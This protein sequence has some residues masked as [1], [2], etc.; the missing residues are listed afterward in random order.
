MSRH[1]FVSKLVTDVKVEQ[2][3][4]KE[5]AVGSGW[6]LKGEILVT[7]AGGRSWLVLIIVT[8]DYHLAV[9]GSISH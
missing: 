8:V 3:G 6:N 2:L 9:C 5:K 7:M 1:L 4:S